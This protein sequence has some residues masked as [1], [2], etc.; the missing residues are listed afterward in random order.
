MP[1]LRTLPPNVGT[2]D[3]QKTRILHRLR[4]KATDLDKYEVSLGWLG[5]DIHTGHPSTSP[6]AQAP[7]LL[8][9]D[10]PHFPSIRFLTQYLVGLQHANQDLFYRTLIDHVPE[11][12]PLVYTP[13][14]GTAC[15]QYRC[16]D[17]DTVLFWF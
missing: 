4:E 1:G 2:V 7:T 5:I 14:I 6:C 12:M 16:V 11:L 8:L 17:G 3:V 10:P 9:T 13:T 15:L